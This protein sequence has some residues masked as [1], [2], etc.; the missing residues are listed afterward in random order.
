MLNQPQI[1]CPALLGNVIL[2]VPR[3]ALQEV[4]GKPFSSLVATGNHLLEKWV[5]ILCLQP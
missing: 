3:W 1:M 5:H 2:T 4:E